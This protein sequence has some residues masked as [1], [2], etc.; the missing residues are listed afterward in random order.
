M[1]FE[2]RLIDVIAKLAPTAA[3]DASQL[4]ADAASSLPQSSRPVEAV[5]K[6]SKASD[7]AAATAAATAATARDR[8]RAAREK[9]AGGKGGGEGGLADGHADRMLCDFVK[10]L[11]ASFLTDSYGVP[12]FVRVLRVFL[13]TAFPATAR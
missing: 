9:G 8:V 12:S 6:K 2:G 11:T 7:A 4:L 5:G 13:R 1:G 3:P 10:D